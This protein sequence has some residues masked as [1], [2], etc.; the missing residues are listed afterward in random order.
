MVRVIMVGSHGVCAHNISRKCFTLNAN[1]CLHLGAVRTASVGDV[2]MH[3]R[4]RVLTLQLTQISLI[5]EANSATS[6]LLP[7][8]SPPPFP[9]P[10]PLPVVCLRGVSLL[11]YE[12][13]GRATSPGSSFL[14]RSSLSCDVYYRMIRTYLLLGRLCLGWG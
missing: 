8:P 1:L 7:S 6:L 13:L 10:P 2:Y 5:C 4:P 11:S 14:P 12:V 9:P 3:V